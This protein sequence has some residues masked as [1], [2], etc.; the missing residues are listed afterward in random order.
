MTMATGR[1]IDRCIH[2]YIEI[3]YFPTNSLLHHVRLIILSSL[4]LKNVVLDNKYD[5]NI[6][7]HINASRYSYRIYSTATIFKYQADIQ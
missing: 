6:F 4:L 1:G 5:R 7:F 3:N 2:T